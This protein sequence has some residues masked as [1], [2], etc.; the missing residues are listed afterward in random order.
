MD[1]VETEEGEQEDA[2]ETFPSYLFPSARMI[3]IYLSIFIAGQ[4]IFDIPDP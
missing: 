3:Y 4:S 1:T 2:V